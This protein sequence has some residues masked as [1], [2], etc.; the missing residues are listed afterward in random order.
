MCSVPLNIFTA[1]NV[2]IIIV[3]G[4]APHCNLFHQS[5]NLILSSNYLDNPKS[6]VY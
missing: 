2:M 6:T 1:L 5:F 3:I 4:L